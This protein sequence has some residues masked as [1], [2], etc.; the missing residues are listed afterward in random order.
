M[1]PPLSFRTGRWRLVAAVAAAVV[2][3]V[4]AAVPAA[5]AG[6]ER[7]V[8][9]SPVDAPVSDPF[10]PPDGTYGAGNRGIEYDTRPGEVVRAAATGTVS[11]AGAVTG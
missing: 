9:R 7:L 3:A 10:R 5:A 1:H 2:T 4:V 8:F 6:D 11:F